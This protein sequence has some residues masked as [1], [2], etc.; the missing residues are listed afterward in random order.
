[1]QIFD[2]KLHAALLEEKLK[3]HLATLVK[4]PILVVV[5]IGDDEGSTRYV[6]AKKK[7]GEKMGIPVEVYK[8]EDSVPLDDLENKIKVLGERKNVGGLIIQLPLPSKE[9]YSLLELVPQ[10]KDV[11]L[12]SNA[13]KKAFNNCDLS[14]LSPV[15]RS[16]KYFVQENNID[17]AALRVGVVGNGQLVGTPI[18]TYLA[19]LGAHSNLVTNYCPGDM[20]NYDLVVLATG[21]PQLVR[22]EDIKVG[23]HVIDFGTYISED[24]IVG[25]L[26]MESVLAHLGVIS[27]TP[28]GMGLLVVRFLFM[29]VLGC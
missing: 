17:L 10:V 11:D 16:F 19:C 4:I 13:A 7:F 29:N 2:G 20:L 9:H 15:V 6:G 24:S 27:P 8:L 28:G 12:L 22:G 21:N 3:A 23:T 1:M 5:Q 25:D 18:H 14:S 26:N